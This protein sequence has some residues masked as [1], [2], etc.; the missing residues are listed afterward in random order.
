M[1][2]V[3]E[4]PYRTL[5]LHNRR[6][7]QLIEINPDAAKTICLVHGLGSNGSS[8]QLQFEILSS[9]GYRVLAPD[10]PGFGGSKFRGGR[11]SIRKAA[12]DLA[13][14]L[15]RLSVQRLDLAGISMGG[16]IG[17]QFELDFPGKVRS[18][19]LA[20][21][22]ASLR[23]AHRDEWFYFIRRGVLT[24]ARGAPE[25]AELVAERIFPG[26]EKA[27]LRRLLVEE[28]RAADPRVYRQALFSLGAFNVQ[29]R[30]K[31]VRART[32]VV[33]GMDD[34]TVPVKNQVALAMGIAGARH[35][36]IANAG[37]AVI[38]D[39]PDAFNRELAA[40]LAGEPAQDG[41][42]PPG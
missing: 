30:L 9:L 6:P 17:L 5:S 21:T 38:I 39:Q 18:L 31:A 10:V 14:M 8:W 27:E 41:N 3:K 37:H 22:F 19:V 42:L 29:N 25:Q 40:F 20:D 13:E 4:F 35:V 32:L 34:T 12:A 33:T 1:L 15:D 23:Q 11:W 24:L 2:A 7:L 36:M 28:I 26:P 16:T